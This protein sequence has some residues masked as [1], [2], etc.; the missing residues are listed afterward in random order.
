MPAS[1]G[2]TDNTRL[3]L[4][5]PLKSQPGQTQPAFNRLLKKHTTNVHDEDRSVPVHSDTRRK[6]YL[7]NT[8]PSV[9]NPNTVSRNRQVARA[10]KARKQSLKRLSTSTLTSRVDKADARRGARPGLLPTSG[11]NKPLSKKKQRKVEKQLAHAIRR[12]AESEAAQDVQ[13]EGA[14]SHCASE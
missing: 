1:Y 6:Q 14:S 13:M 8:M 12:K 4:I 11:P 2:K 7:H 10:A 3:L 5:A 9:K